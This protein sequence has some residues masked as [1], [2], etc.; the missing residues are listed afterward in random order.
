MWPNC[1]T[2]VEMM[3]YSRFD[4]FIY[5][6]VQCDFKIEKLPRRAA[7][8]RRSNGIRQWGVPAA[9]TDMKPEQW[10]LQQK[11]PVDKRKSR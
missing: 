10:S 6:F 8:Y 1:K 4:S 7:E 11:H 2:S 9:A 5:S 3:F